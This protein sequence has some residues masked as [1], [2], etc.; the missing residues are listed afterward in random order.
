MFSLNWS[1]LDDAGADGQPAFS[2]IS[3]VTAS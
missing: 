2:S 1:S 3:K